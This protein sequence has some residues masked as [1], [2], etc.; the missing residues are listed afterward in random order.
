[1]DGIEQFGK[2]Y[3]GKHQWQEILPDEL[4]HSHCGVWLL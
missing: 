1:M 4:L 3:R 2:A